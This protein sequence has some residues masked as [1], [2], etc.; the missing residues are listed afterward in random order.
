MDAKGQTEIT[1]DFVKAFA[2]A[3]PVP[4]DFKQMF[5]VYLDNAGRTV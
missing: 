3:L 5:S 4:A 2:S 1:K